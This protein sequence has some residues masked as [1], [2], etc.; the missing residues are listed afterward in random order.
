MI[1]FSPN[2]TRWI[3]ALIGIITGVGISIFL[4]NRFLSQSGLQKIK[5]FIPPAFLLVLATMGIVGYFVQSPLYILLEVIILIG[6]KEM[7][8]L[9][10]LK[11]CQSCIEELMID[12]LTF[13]SGSLNHPM[14]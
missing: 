3:T 13:S 10:V 6:V 14:L 2:L 8:L 1:M 9:L 7:R 12:S 4:V 5:R 11:K